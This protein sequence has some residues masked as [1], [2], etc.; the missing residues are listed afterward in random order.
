MR[1][2]K[3][4]SSR[5]SRAGCR[6]PAKADGRSKPPLMKVCRC[7]CL[8]R[9]FMRDSLRAAR[10]ISRASCSRPCATD[11]AAI[12]RNPRNEKRRMN[13]PHSDA[14]VFFG[15]TGD[16]IYKKIFPAL[17]AM[18]RRGRLK[19]RYRGREV[20]LDDRE[21]SGACPYDP[22]YYAANVFDPDRYSLEAVC[23]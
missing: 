4:P 15:A 21:V 23:K 2:P 11:S 8:P 6:T 5:N 14:L 18:E 19:A 3:I 12:W 9:R 20:G 10:P 22:R 7:R 1:W 13:L 17:Y 16:L